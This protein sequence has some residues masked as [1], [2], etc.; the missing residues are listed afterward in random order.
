MAPPRIFTIGYEKKPITS[1]L[2]ILLR[3]KMDILTD[4]RHNAFSMRPD[5]RKARLATRL[6]EAGLE[7]VHFPG[8]GIPGRVRRQFDDRESPAKLLSHYSRN[9]LPE[10]PEDFEKLVS[11]GR[12]KRIVLMCF[13]KDVE[14][15]HRGIIAQEIEKKGFEVVHL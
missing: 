9:I 2:D 7:Y 15:C 5:F 14:C 8:L 6:S 10:N 12:T 11:L 1:F 13:E 3:N 4:V